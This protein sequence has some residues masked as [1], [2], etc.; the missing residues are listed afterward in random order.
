MST[1]TLLRH[2]RVDIKE[3]DNI[4]ARDFGQW[5]DE[6]N[7]AGIKKEVPNQDTIFKLLDEADII[8]CSNLNRS[9]ESVALFGKKP[10]YI[11]ELFNEVELP[12]ASWKTI[13]LRASFWLVF[14]RILWFLGYSKNVESYRKAQIRAKE[15]SEILFDFAK[16]GQS[17]V[18]VG[19]GLMNKLIVKEL[20]GKNCI[21]LKSTGSNN[22]SYSI[23]E[24]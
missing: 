2:A 19:H 10:T 9:I 6:Y 21:K 12:T 24:I 23:L 11:N 14:F 3:F 15:A 20:L 17:V 7:T 5:I 1:I 8:L 4:T 13:Q 18:L 22:W 16:E